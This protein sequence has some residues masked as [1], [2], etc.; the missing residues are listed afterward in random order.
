[1]MER[2]QA[3]LVQARRDADTRERPFVTLSYAQSLDGCITARAGSSLP[4]SCPEALIRTHQLRA[5]HDAIL[6]GIGTVLVDDPR[7]TVRLAPGPHPQPV[8]VDSHLR[9]PTG[10]RLLQGPVAPW[11]ATLAGAD[12]ARAEALEA[13]GA[14]LLRLP[15]DARGRVDPRALL[16]RL[17][18]EGIV[19]LMIEGG[20]QIITSFLAARL[21][22]Q[23]VLTVAPM[24]VGGQRAVASLQRAEGDC[25]LSLRD[26]EYEPLGSDLIVRADVDWNGW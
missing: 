22:D 8:V 17:A 13:A 9:F 12:P 1:M 26:V 3:M 14:R 10:A 15:A 5:M 19:A 23:L 21:V 2:I 11:I 25:L 18:R 24:L 20:T 6:V 16:V 7:L 4:L